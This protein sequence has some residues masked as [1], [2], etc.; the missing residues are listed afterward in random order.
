M[1]THGLTPLVAHSPPPFRLSTPDKVKADLA[2]E[3]V[4]FGAAETK[5]DAV[6][7]QAQQ[8]RLCNEQHQAK[9]KASQEVRTQSGDSS[10]PSKEATNLTN[11]DKNNM[12]DDNQDWGL[13][14]LE[15]RI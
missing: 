1:S 12:G 13:S 4:R 15:T 14:D 11:L 5:P 10:N 2:R 6:A 9:A 7:D 3:Q 8:L